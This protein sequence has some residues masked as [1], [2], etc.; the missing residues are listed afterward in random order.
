MA[1]TKKIKS[2]AKTSR[3]T[4]LRRLLE[5][6]RR[7]LVNDVQ[8]RMHDVRR[9]A[10]NDRGVLDDGET[11]DVDVQEEIELALLQLKSETL[12]KVNEALRRLDQGTYGNC[13]EC[14]DEI[15]HARL[16]ALPFALRCR[17]CEEARETTEERARVAAQHRGSRPLFFD[18]ST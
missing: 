14:G 9:D 10:A 8:D 12:H 3:Y 11:S 16:R 5:D 4:E 2:A 6:R 17:D 7:E 18:T 1:T 15:S 13:F